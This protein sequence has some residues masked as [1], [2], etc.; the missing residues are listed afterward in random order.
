MVQVTGSV[1]VEKIYSGKHLA[2]CFINVGDPL[3]LIFLWIR[4]QIRFFSFARNPSHV[5]ASAI[6]E[7]LGSPTFRQCPTTLDQK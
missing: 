3:I 7:I 1:K 5:L 2:K 4:A 6:I